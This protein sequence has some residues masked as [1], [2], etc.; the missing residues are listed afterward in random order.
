MTDET[1]LALTPEQIAVVNSA[2][3][4]VYAHDPATQRRFRLVEQP[5][6]ERLTVKELRGMIE[7]ALAESERGECRPWDAEE[8]KEE[9]RREY[10]KRGIT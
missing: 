3:G 4:A 2:S 10:A 1:F 5:P 7:V 6:G 9:I 8:I